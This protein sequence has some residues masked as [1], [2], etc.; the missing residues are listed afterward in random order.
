M[1]KPYYHLGCP[2]IFFCAPAIIESICYCTRENQLINKSNTT[3]GLKKV[4]TGCRCMA[5]N[6]SNHVPQL[7]LAVK[8]KWRK[9]ENTTKGADILNN[10]KLSH[11]NLQLCKFCYNLNWIW[12]VYLVFI[13][14]YRL[15]FRMF[16]KYDSH[17]WLTGRTW[18]IT[19]IKSSKELYRYL[20]IC[21]LLFIV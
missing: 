4:W 2:S 14:S 11:C 18:P 19:K 16:K 21:Y 3:G 12:R 5:K 1:Y 10:Q 8:K 20:V 17:A 9:G 13:I 6:A 7:Q 15:S